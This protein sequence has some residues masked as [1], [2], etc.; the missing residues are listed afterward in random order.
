MGNE[1][2]FR[3]IW[4]IRFS[5]T[6]E[7]VK[8]V[9]SHIVPLDSESL[10]VT[11]SI[12]RNEGRTRWLFT[13][14]ASPDNLATIETSWTTCTQSNWKLQGSLCPPVQVQRQLA[15]DAPERCKDELQQ[16][17][18][19]SSIEQE[20]ELSSSTIPHS[21]LHTDAKADTT[22][23]DDALNT[24]TALPVED[25]SRAEPVRSKVP[26]C[27]AASYPESAVV[28][29]EA[30]LTSLECPPGGSPNHV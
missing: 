14:M 17:R 10:Q 21:A 7:S 9:L 19:S 18:A 1:A 27:D 28:D 11:K 4:G 2:S 22:T 25:L 3:V 12:R 16:P 13:I 24:S 26:S 29:T 15:V 20:P 6:M 5:T 8:S 23:V 30:S